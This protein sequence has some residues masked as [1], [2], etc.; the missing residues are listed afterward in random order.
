MTRAHR[1]RPVDYIHE[2]VEEDQGTASNSVAPSLVPAATRTAAALLTEDVDDLRHR[3][4]N[5][6]VDIE[7]THQRVYESEWGVLTQQR[8]AQSPTDLLSELGDLGFAW[9]DIARMVGVTVPAVQKWRRGERI[10]G[11]NRLKVAKLMAVCDFLMAHYYVDDVAS[12]FEMPLNEAAPITPVDLWASGQTKLFFDYATRHVTA[13]ET[14]TKYEPDW[15][16]RYRSDYE[17]FRDA[18]GGIGIRTRDR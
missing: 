3:A 11:P 9:R 18:D 14:L 13:D 12:W 6:N 15:R 5:L 4:K 7:E 10:T 2:I 8:G 1:R 16:E 17:T